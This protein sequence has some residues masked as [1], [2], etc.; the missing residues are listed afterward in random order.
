MMTG[1]AFG[2]EASVLGLIGP[3]LGILM[4]LAMRRPAQ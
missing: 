4:M 3:M 1:G 2:L